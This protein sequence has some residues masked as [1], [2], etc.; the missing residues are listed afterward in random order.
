MVEAHDGGLLGEHELHQGAVAAD[1]AAGEGVVTIVPGAGGALG[2]TIELGY[3]SDAE[4]LADFLED[5]G[6]EAVAEGEADF[7]G[8]LGWGD[9][10]GEEVAEGFADVLDYCRVVV[11]DVAPEALGAEPV[12]KDEGGA[13]PEGG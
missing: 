7:V 10:G 6:A 4:A 9:G 11:C 1:G 13:A 5:V 8:P 2:G 3:G 12:A